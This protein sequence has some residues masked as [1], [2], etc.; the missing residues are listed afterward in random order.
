[1]ST[2][3]TLAS[4]ILDDIDRGSAYDARVKRAIFD[5]IDS[6]ADK[7]LSFNTKKTTFDI[8]DE[9]EDF[10]TDW[11]DTDYLTLLTSTERR[12]LCEKTFKWIESRRQDLSCSDEPIVYAVQNGQIRLYPPPDETYSV[13]ISYQYDL[14][15]GADSLSDSFSTAWLKQGKALIRAEALAE[16][17]EFYIQGPESMEM[18]D[19]YRR[20]AA[21]RY[22]KLK[23]KSNKAESTG[24]VQPFL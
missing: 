5:A 3:R 7:R 16:L 19:R 23:S 15:A 9:Y 1:M 10:P 22:K 20:E 12:P 6:Y 17:Y 2:V 4:E 14:R 24:R 21:R 8:R 18:A 13:E 11:L